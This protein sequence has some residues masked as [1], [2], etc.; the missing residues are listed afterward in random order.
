MYKNARAYTVM[1][2]YVKDYDQYWDSKEG[3]RINITI[4]ALSPTDYN[5]LT[6]EKYDSF[7]LECEEQWASL[8]GIKTEMHISP[9]R[10]VHYLKISNSISCD[11]TNTE[12]LLEFSDE[13]Y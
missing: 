10:E 12:W 6:A 5:T 3:W 9:P 7:V 1:L 4:I 8:S 13:H 2:R 11:D